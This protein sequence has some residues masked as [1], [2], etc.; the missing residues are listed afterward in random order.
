MQSDWN[1]WPLISSDGDT[2]AILQHISD[3]N[4][5]VQVGIGRTRTA[6]AAI[7]GNSRKA[8]MCQCC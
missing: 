5:E 4:V 8:G 7:E 6:R 2:A 1:E 3:H